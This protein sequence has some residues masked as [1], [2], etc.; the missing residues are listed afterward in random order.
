MKI[1]IFVSFL[2]LLAISLSANAVEISQQQAKE[3]ALAFMLKR[4]GNNAE[5]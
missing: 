2:L 5:R 3:K 1:R 4:K